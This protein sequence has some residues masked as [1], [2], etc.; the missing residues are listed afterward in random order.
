[1]T[2]QLHRDL[3]E[4]LN[5]PRS[6][7]GWQDVCGVDEVPVD[8]GVAALVDGVAVAVFRLSPS[9]V[10]GAEEWYAVSHVD[11]ATGAPVMARGLV[12]STADE[13]P[14]PTVASPL[15]KQRYDLRTG[16]CLDDGTLALVVHEVEVVIDA[17]TDRGARVRVR[18]GA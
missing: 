13:P 14:V 1:M 15:H 8:R 4:R 6:T 12:G 11:P 2:S 3:P 10:G 9:E 18:P 5:G 17:E 7:A 16:R